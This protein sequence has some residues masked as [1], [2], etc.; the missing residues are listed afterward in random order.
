L[1]CDL[2]AADGTGRCDT[3][4]PPGA[5]I[6]VEVVSVG[7]AL[8]ERTDFD[9]FVADVEPR[10]RRALVAAYGP[11]AGR[12]AVADALAWAWQNWDRLRGM[13]NP[14][15]YLWRVGQSAVRSAARRSRRELTA[16]VEVELQ[17]RDAHREP[18]V[19]PALDGALAELSPQ[20]RAAVVLVHGYGYSLSEAAA[21]LS[22]SV[23]TVRNHVQRALRRLHAALEVSEVSDE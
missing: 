20:Q 13:D 8:P 18:R 7:T 22:C 11:E 2:V 15:G 16:V 6:D 9:D 12:E 5:F 10:L 21:V 4:G 19:E 3:I 23:S 17:P 1:C 14:S